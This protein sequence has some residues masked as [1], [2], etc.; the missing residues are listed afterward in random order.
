MIGTYLNQRYRIDQEIGR[1]GL[2]TIYKALDTLLDRPV[3]IKVLN[4][5]AGLGTEGQAR[6]LN[7]ARA[8]ARLNHPNIVSIFDAGKTDPVLNPQQDLAFIVMELVEGDSL[9][10]KKPG[11][12][13][14]T[15]RISLQICAALQAAH[16]SGIIHRDLKPENVLITPDGTAKLTD[17]GLARSMSSRLTQEGTLV[18]TV[19]YIAPEMALGQPVD[20]RTDLYGLGVMLYELTSGQLPFSADDPLAV[21]SQHIHAPVVPPSTYN[22]AIPPALDDLILRLM[23]KQ[24]SDRPASATEVQH[25]IENILNPTQ[26]AVLPVASHSPLERLVRGKLVGREKELA[27][28][29]TIWK[30]VLSGTNQTPVLAISGEA[31][32]GK[33]PFLRELT[34]LFE[35]SGATVLNGE[36]Y[37]E[38]SAPYTPIVEM[39]RTALPLAVNVPE[40][41]QSSLR[42]LVP[43]YAIQSAGAAS[44]AA[45]PLSEQQR[46]FENMLLLC[47]SLA[48]TAPLVLV[49]EDTH[50]IDGNSMGMIRYLARRIRTLRPTPRI[51]IVLTYRDTDME[52]TCCLEDMLIDMRL[53]KLVYPI[54]LERFS[55]EQ[56]GELLASMFKG[57]ISDDFVD[58][59]FQVTEGNFFFIEEMCKALIEQ[60]KITS[61]GSRWIIQPGIQQFELPQ[62]VRMTIQ[63]RVNN[64]DEQTQEI[65]RVAAVIGRDFDFA[66]LQ[67]ASSLDEDTIITALEKAVQAQLIVEA[68]PRPGS[69][70]NQEAFYFAH[71]L[72][73]VFLR[74][75]IS[76][77]R[78]HRLHRRI[79]SALQALR[80]DDLETLAYHAEQAGDEPVARKFTIQA[81]D[82]ALSLY[83][84]REAER[85]YRL[86]L[87]MELDENQRTLVM[88]SLGEAL[89]RLS[90][91]PQAV[92]IWEKSAERFMHLHDYDHAAHT[93]ARAARAVWYSPDWRR[94]VEIC[95]YALARIR[96]AAEAA[97]Q[98]ETPGF[99]A[100]LHE[101]ARSYRFTGQ[102]D[103][104][105]PLCREALDLAEKLN[106]VEVRADALATLGI[107]P[108]VSPEE[109]RQALTKAV[110]LAESAGL[111]M[112]AVRAHENLSGLLQRA[113]D[114]SASRAHHIRSREITQKLG[115]LDWEYDQL[116]KIAFISIEMGDFPVA[117]TTLERM[118]SL[119][120]LIS[121]AFPAALN[122]R[123]I[124]GHLWAFQGK[125]EPAVQRYQECLEEARKLPD[126]LIRADILV[127]L[128]EVL[129]MLDRN[130]EADQLMHE[131]V[132]L[133][134]LEPM[135]DIALSSSLLARVRIQQG[136]YADAQQI[137][138]EALIR[139]EKAQSPVDSARI[140]LC[141]AHLA[142][143]DHRWD[144]VETAYQEVLDAIR[145]LKLT[146][147]EARV[148]LYQAQLYFNYGT[149]KHW[150][151]VRSLLMQ[152]RQIFL[153]LKA[154]G[155]VD[156]ID[157]RLA[158]LP[159][160][161]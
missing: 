71:G 13:T 104:A 113:G 117:E 7:E 32:V 108:N 49:I 21:I 84:N 46:L 147:Y 156:W 82:R 3:A 127:N 57:E 131:M 90:Q 61:E 148:L 38:G 19:Y 64:L 17:F 60:G 118:G 97:G 77:L 103:Q 33:S 114:Y 51:W 106:L 155:Y 94:C 107:L 109:T 62:S 96:T 126:V 151:T 154:D 80:P 56:T 161:F 58:T 40:V 123:F 150:P 48:A 143:A 99:A 133:D 83:A 116:G 136:R 124:Q 146:W 50:W 52:N 125:L 105:L 68:R 31:G 41:I 73:P 25:W 2:G 79:L 67:H 160:T 132:K 28:V 81:A 159:E 115:I 9:H 65:L 29:K 92:K 134:I 47:Q 23:S 88:A 20:A 69:T 111:L 120:N 93:F 87:D 30:Q 74:D 129:L 102:H 145:Q 22:A 144:E 4:T 15:L 130:E 36:C 98:L 149:P 1:G 139:L 141:E 10:D 5:A 85:Y 63:A 37:S 6:L 43:E 34:A 112:I 121:T 42:H 158:L 76:T 44:P 95:E 122:R 140:R 152:S 54:R 12:I 18:G 24:P 142:A 66:V 119:E 91:Y 135:A 78:R 8:A 53:E 137:I 11:S 89:F 75:G 100:L 45:D 128:V 27:E 59:I 157:A 16:S 138:N 70:N 14:E 39:L 72:V 35:V 153:K 86:A 101:T 110:E 55:R 26:Q